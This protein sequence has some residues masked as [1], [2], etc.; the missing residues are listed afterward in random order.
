MTTHHLANQTSVQLWLQPVICCHDNFSSSEL[1]TIQL[2]YSL[3]SVFVF[4]QSLWG[5][6]KICSGIYSMPLLLLINHKWRYTDSDMLWQSRNLCCGLLKFPSLI[7]LLR[8]WMH[9]LTY[10]LILFNHIHM[11]QVSLRPNCID[12][13]GYCIWPVKTVLIIWKN[14]KWKF[15]Y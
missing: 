12:A 7:T 14:K 1:G 15:V 2:W 4:S 8:T 11:G 3:T 5:L 9:S 13:F 10:L 6:L